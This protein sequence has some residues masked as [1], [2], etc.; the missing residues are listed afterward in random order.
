MRLENYPNELT[1]EDADAGFLLHKLECRRSL[2][3][4]LTG[5]PYQEVVAYQLSKSDLIIRIQDSEDG[6]PRY[7]R[8]RWG[9]VVFVG[10]KP[11]DAPGWHICEQ[12][13]FSDPGEAIQGFL[14]E[15]E[16]EGRR[17]IIPEHFKVFA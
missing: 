14:F 7:A 10:L 16:P 17:K 6:R 2:L 1:E 13:F 15:S 9:R 4:A 11:D 12:V 3:T 8:H 5:I